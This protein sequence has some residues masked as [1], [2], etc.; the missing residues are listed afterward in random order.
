MKKK[1]WHIAICFCVLAFLTRGYSYA[2]LVTDGAYTADEL[3]SALVG[4]GV[5][6]SGA[7]LNCSGLASGVF[8]CVDCN[9]GIDSGIILT[10]GYI[11]NAEGPNDETGV[12]GDVGTPGDPDLTGLAGQPTFDACVL[13]FDVTVDFD[14]LKF[15]YVF[16]SDEYTTYVNTAYNDIFAFLISGPGIV[17]EVNM[18]QIPGTAIPVSIN[19]VNPLEYDEYYIDNGVGCT[20]LFGGCSEGVLGPPYTTDDYYINYDGFTVVLTAQ[21]LVIP[22][23]TY[24]LKLAIADAGDPVL[25]S[26]VF[27]KSRSLTSPGIH[28]SQATSVGAGFDNAIEECVDAY[29]IFTADVPPDEDLTIHFGI[30]GT[31]LNGTDYDEIPDSITIAAGTLSDSIGIFPISDFITEGF[32]SVIIYLFGECD[33][34]P[35]DSVTVYIQ[36]KVELEMNIEPDTTICIFDSLMLTVTGGLDYYWDPDAYISTTFGDTVIVSP[37]VTQEYHVT[38]YLG[39]CVGH[40]TVTVIVSPPPDAYLGPDAAICLGDTY[41]FLLPPGNTYTWDPPT[42]LDDPAANDPI[43]SP[44]AL[45]SITYSVAVTDAFGC[46]NYDTLVLTVQSDPNA[47]VFPDTLVCPGEPVQL[48]ADGGSTYLWYPSG[49][50]SNTDISNPIATVTE[51][52]IFNVIV[53]D[54]AGCDDTVSVHVDIE[55]FPAV[56]AGPLTVIFK[57]EST[58]LQGSSDAPVNSWWPPDFLSDI[59]VLDPVANPDETIWYYLTAISPIGCVSIDSVHIVVVEPEAAIVPNA[60]S[61]NGDG[62]NDELHI[63][64]F[65]NIEL[66]SFAIFNRWGEKIFE[67]NDILAGWDGTFAGEP[68]EVGVYI[69]I[70]TGLNEK[71]ENIQYHGTISLLR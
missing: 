33:G 36:D 67:T 66:I 14:T 21:S 2:Q 57:G 30:G 5:E 59:N 17:G 55:P 22:C 51:S 32:E 68:Q 27:I 6:V 54:A 60:F 39:A 10:S 35:F 45:G 44:D 16:G 70:L 47:I 18:A 71:N 56:D 61:P 7:S 43:S 1:T 31:A 15:Q 37:P 24:H 12:T 11:T 3:A 58:V 64:T 46:T 26:G 25:D 13:E 8:D 53:T 62:V 34:E 38:T 19:N 28:L 40:D 52:T 42:Y 41:Q 48:N 65:E 50:L 69:Y 29:V 9:V 4:S 49:G 63:V 20:P 23:E